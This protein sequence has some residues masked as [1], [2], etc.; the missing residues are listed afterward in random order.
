MFIYVHEEDGKTQ[1]MAFYT[2]AYKIK[3]Y[4][5]SHFYF[6]GKRKPDK[7]IENENINILS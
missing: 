5:F 6:S 1:W 2:D 4:I 3:Y 7:V